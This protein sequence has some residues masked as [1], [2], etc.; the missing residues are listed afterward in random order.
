VGIKN[1]RLVA[2][3]LLVTPDEGGAR[4]Y[5]LVNYLR[6]ADVPDLTI[7]SLTLLTTLAQ[8]MIILIRTLQD[9]EILGEEFAGDFDMEYM[10]ETLIDDLSAED[11]PQ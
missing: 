10:L 4:E 7:N 3:K 11:V 8:V 6:A 1:V 9:K 2:G 5:D